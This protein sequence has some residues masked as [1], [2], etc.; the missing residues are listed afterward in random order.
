MAELDLQRL[1]RTARMNLRRR[2]ARRPIAFVMSGGGSQGS[3][4]A[5]VLRFLYDD[6]G[7]RPS[8]LVG[9]SVGAIIAAKLAEGDDDETGRRAI[10]EVE[11]IWRGLKT[12]ADMWVIEP[13]LEKLRSQVTW[14]SELR[15][16]AGDRAGLR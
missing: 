14:A 6:V 13:W 9:S 1:A 10:D 7:L 16:R 15:G 5:G 8:I 12:N 2:M 4:E 3:F 11:A